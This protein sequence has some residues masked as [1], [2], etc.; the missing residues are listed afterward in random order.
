MESRKTTALFYYNFKM[1]NGLGMH[2]L[3]L[4]MKA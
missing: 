1:K 4:K 2:T 3:D